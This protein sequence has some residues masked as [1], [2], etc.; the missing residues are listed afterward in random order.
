[1]NDF[2]ARLQNGG[3]LFDGSMGA[4]IEARGVTTNCPAL[5]NA[6]NPALIRAIHQDYRA[7]GADVSIANTFGANP[8]KLRA[9]GLENRL[10]ELI[11][12][13]EKADLDQIEKDI[14]IRDKQDMEREIAPLKQAEDAVLVDSSD[15]TIEEVVDC[16]MKEF[17]KVK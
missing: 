2:L 3:L 4:L 16:I 17:E 14:I 8:I 1:M 12:K 11:E 6:E 13:G 9:L 5:L 7:A 10:D 15:M